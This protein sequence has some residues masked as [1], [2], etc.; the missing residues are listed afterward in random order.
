[1][2]GQSPIE[3]I[4]AC[5]A[6]MIASPSDELV[7]PL[8]EAIAHG[9]RSGCV[10]SRD[11]DG[12]AQAIFHL[13]LGVFVTHTTIGRPASRKELEMAVMGTIRGALSVR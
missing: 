1:M 8:R 10:S 5:V 2:C 4:H 7:A 3:R 9:C 12:D 11:P 13:V 6:A